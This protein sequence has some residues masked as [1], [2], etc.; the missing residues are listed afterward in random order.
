MP[1][2]RYYSI[3]LKNIKAIIGFDFEKKEAKTI[4]C[5][6]MES[7]YKYKFLEGGKCPYH[8]QAISEFRKYALRGRIVS[9][10]IHEVEKP[11]N[12]KNSS[13]SDLQIGSWRV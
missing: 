9:A 1:D 5:S 6:N 11:V 8:C 3:K 7:C 13:I 4:E 10:D 12:I 2:Y